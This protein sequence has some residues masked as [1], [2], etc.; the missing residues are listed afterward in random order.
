MNEAVNLLRSIQSKKKEK[1]EYDSFGE[2]VAIKLRKITS[3]QARFQAQQIINKTLFEAEMGMAGYSYNAN[4]HQQTYPNI[5]PST[6]QNYPQQTYQPQLSPYPLTQSPTLNSQYSSSSFSASQ[7]P[8]SVRS[9]NISNNL[10]GQPELYENEI[11]E[12]Y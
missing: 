4:T 5:F 9:D 6:N 7:S 1:D 3:P 10:G 8:S 2:Q 12:L 11:R